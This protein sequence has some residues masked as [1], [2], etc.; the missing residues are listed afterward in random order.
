LLFA[1]AFGTFGGLILFL[2]TTQRFGA[3]AASL[4]SYVLPVVA[5][6]GG[7]LFLDETITRVMLAGMALIIAGIAILNRR[8]PLPIEV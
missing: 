2:Y 8:E 7:V 6:V 1:V 4:T 5:A 3:T